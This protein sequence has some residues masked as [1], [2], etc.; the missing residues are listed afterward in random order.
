MTTMACARAAELLSDDLEGA[1]DGVTAADLAAHLAECHD[2]RELRAAVADVSALLRVPAIEP[3]PALAE[4]VAR[5][6]WAAARPVVA[7]VPRARAW[8]HTAAVGVSWL[9]DVPFAVQAIAA[10][11][12]LVLTA[13]LVM[14]AGSAPGTAARPRVAQRLSD[15]TVYVVER[16]ERLVE[17]FRLL[18]VVIGTAFE[19]RLDRVNDR[20]DDYRR[21]LERRQ[22]EQAKERGKKTQ[23]ALGASGW[24]AA[25]EAA[26]ETSEPAARS[27]R[28][29]V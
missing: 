5:A 17:D 1:L 14:A 13:G 29:S 27:S 22:N 28:R 12:A 26:R 9:T 25:A 7:R 3:S 4:R 24:A 19:G 10:G 18:R 21:L 23:A 8:I 20:V 16:K 2:C 11:F 15:A 6:S